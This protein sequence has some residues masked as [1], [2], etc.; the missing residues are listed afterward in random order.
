M[1][2]A[3]E[4]AKEAAKKFDLKMYQREPTRN[5]L[6]D[7]ASDTWEPLLR[8]TKIYLRGDIYQ[9]VKEALGDKY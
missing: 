6:V 7:V 4:Q 2:T 1:T 5:E 9:K 3:R 8:E